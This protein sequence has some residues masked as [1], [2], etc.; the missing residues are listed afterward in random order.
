[1]RQIPFVD[2]EA[3]I[4]DLDLSRTIGIVS[5]KIHDKWD[6]FNFKAVTFPFLDGDVHRSPSIIV[7]VIH[8]L[9]VV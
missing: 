8:K 6:G 1:M 7:Y 9:F 3:R 5:S 4:L 2:T